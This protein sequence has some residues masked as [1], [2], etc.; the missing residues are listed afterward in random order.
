MSHKKLQIIMRVEA[1]GLTNFLIMISTE[2]I[3]YLIIKINQFY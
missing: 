2:K 1:Y 3:S